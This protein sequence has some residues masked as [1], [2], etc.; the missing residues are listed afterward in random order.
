MQREQGMDVIVCFRP[1]CPAPIS[2]KRNR[3][4]C[5][6]S[7]IVIGVSLT[8]DVSSEDLS[9]AIGNRRGRQHPFVP[10]CGA[11]W[12]LVTESHLS[13]GWISEHEGSND[14]LSKRET[15]RRWPHGRSSITFKSAPKSLSRGWLSSTPH[16]HGRMRSN[17]PCVLPSYPLSISPTFLA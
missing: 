2:R 8:T 15:L 14:R 10:L 3:L 6:P 4:A 11:D 1:V 16:V 12:N 17:V 13:K 5:A 9:L 7:K